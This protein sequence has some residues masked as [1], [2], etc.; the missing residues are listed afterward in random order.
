MRG[1]KGAAYMRRGA[2][3]AARPL[4]AALQCLAQRGDVAHAGGL[5]GVDH[6]GAAAVH[7]EL[8]PLVIGLKMFAGQSTGNMGII[9][10]ER[11]RIVFSALAD[12]T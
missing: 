10:R 6:R 5:E 2:P 3:D 11:Q 4:C 12:C 7:D 1:T 8:F 9:G